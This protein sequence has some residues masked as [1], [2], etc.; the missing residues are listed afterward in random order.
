MYTAYDLQVNP[1][2]GFYKHAE[3][4]ALIILLNFTLFWSY[5][6]LFMSIL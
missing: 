6:I 2:E 1:I 3:Q 5:L 4:N